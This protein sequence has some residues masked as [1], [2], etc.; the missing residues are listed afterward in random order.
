MTNDIQ[1]RLATETDSDYVN[2]YTTYG[3]RFVRGAYEALL[4]PAGMKEY[5]S[6]DNRLRNGSQYAALAT[7]AKKKAREVAIPFSIEASTESAFFT[8]YEAFLEKVS[9]GLVYLRVPR[10]NKVFKVVYTSCDRFGISQLKD[11]IFTLRMIEPD[12]TD[13]S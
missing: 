12:P 7:S 8:R 4:T 9:S 6:N 2:L 10:L 13:R 11:A 1:I 3:V 5:I